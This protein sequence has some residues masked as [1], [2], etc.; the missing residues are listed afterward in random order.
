MPIQLVG[1]QECLREIDY[2]GGSVNCGAYQALAL[3]EDYTDRE[4][5]VIYDPEQ[6]RGSPGLLPLGLNMSGCSGG[7]AVIHHT[8]NSTHRWYPVGLIVGGPCGQQ[9]EGDSANYDTIHIRRID[10]I[11]PDGHI[12]VPDTGWLP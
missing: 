3:V 2:A 8:R 11:E 9:G 6:S 7:P 5:I 4:I 10:C 1:F 12:R